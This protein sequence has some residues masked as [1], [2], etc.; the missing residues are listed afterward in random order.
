VSNKSST[1]P[2]RKPDFL[3]IGAAKSGTTSLWHQLS[4]HPQIFMHPA[5]N[6]NFFA[7]EGQS[8]EFRGPPPLDLS[9]YS[10]R[11]WEDYCRKFSAAADEIAVGEAS[12]SYLY[13][14][15]AASRIKTHI[16]EAKLI[17]V[18]R[19][20]AERAYSRFLQ[21]A[22][23]GRERI[24]DFAD[25]LKAEAARVDDRW[26]PEVHYLQAGLYHAQ[27]SR[28]YAVFPPDRI[29]VFL[30]EDMLTEPVRILRD[31][32]QF[33]NVN[34]GFT[35]MMD[36]RYSASGLPKRKGVDWV[37]RKL[38]L[39]RPMA[40]KL[41]PQSQLNSV[42]RLAGAI[43]ARNLSRPKISPEARHWMIQRYREDTLRLQDLIQRD[44]SVWLR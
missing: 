37:L 33:L 35:P 11:T 5:K 12:N 9:V 6:L 3:I 36:V 39:A 23:S 30:Y 27:L 26:W 43:H 34:T 17:A 7:I 15:G 38:R 4:Q 40:E 44:L 2:G 14:A 22:G 29:K 16:P 19:H 32:F 24:A 21:V 13:S 41:L 8:V 42:L 25:A 20:P 10:T 18:L 31:I 28:Y 1:K